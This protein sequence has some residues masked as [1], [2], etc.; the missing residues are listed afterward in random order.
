MDGFTGFTVGDG[1]LSCRSWESVDRM[2]MG[3]AARA[4][5]HG[6]STLYEPQQ[7]SMAL[8]ETW[9]IE[10]DT[11]G[12]IQGSLDTAF[13]GWRRGIMGFAEFVVA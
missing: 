6:K 5:R 4:G 12:W 1:L 9:W 7:W 3:M 2:G 8:T 10:D 13:G 11:E